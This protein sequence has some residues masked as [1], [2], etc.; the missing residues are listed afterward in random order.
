MARGWSGGK[1]LIFTGI[2]IRAN[3]SSGKR[4]ARENTVEQH[5]QSTERKRK[6]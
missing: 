1:H 3:S 2:K 6:Q 4:N 5:L